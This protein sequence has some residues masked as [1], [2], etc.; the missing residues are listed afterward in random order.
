MQTQEIKGNL[1]KL[2]ATENLVVE[3]RNC[4]TAS[5]DVDN[6]VLT[7]PKWDRAS[8]TVYDLLVGHEVGHALYTPVW[9]TFNCPRDYVNVTEDAR[10]EKLMKRRY[11]GLRK[12]FF[13]GYNELH[14]Q[15]FF[16]IGDDDLDTFKLID[17]INLYFKIGSAGLDVT[18]TPEEQELVD[19]TA[20]AET[21]EQ[22]VA[23]A[24]KI[25]QF[26]KAEQSQMEKLADVPQS[27]GDGGSGSS[28][29]QES[30]QYN[31]SNDSNTTTNSDEGSESGDDDQ[32]EDVDGE[33]ASGG[34]TGDINSSDTQDAFDRA[35]EQLNNRFN[36]GRTI[37][38][39]MP[40]LNPSDYV[41]DWQT[42]H[43]WIDESRGEDADTSFADS[44]FRQF[45]KS[46]AKEV[47]YLVKEFECKKAAD[48]YSRSMTSRTGVLDTSKLH[49]FKYNEDLFKKVTVIP[50]GKNHGLLFIL[51]W[52]GSMSGVMLPTIK[53]LLTL[54]FFCKKVG[55]PFEVHA[56]TNEWAAA[57]RAIEGKTYPDY[58]DDYY[59]DGTHVVKNEMYVSKPFFRMMNLLSSR[60]NTKNF[61]RQCL[62]V[63]R[64]VFIMHYYDKYSPTIGM[65][66][67][68]TPL[69]ES[70]V[71]MK[72]IIPQ[73]KKSNNLNK[74]NVC[75]LTDGESC[76]S[77][78]GCEIVGANDF[79]RV[80]PRRIDY[81]DIV[82]R[83]R[84]IGRMYPKSNGFIDQTNLFI[85]NLKE[86]HPSVNVVGFRLIESTGL[87]N[88]CARYCNAEYDDI[89]N[90][91]KQWK[92]EKSAVMPK[93]ISYDALYAIHARSTNTEDTGLDVEEG[94]SKTQ[95][96]TAFK[97]ML[98]KKHNN[99]KILNSFISLIS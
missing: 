1:A 93:P 45:K 82:I 95:L 34:T 25:W 22:A 29:T 5:F 65:G 39:D 10:V 86:T 13:Q 35:T 92:K 26:A 16:G 85:Q 66:L 56:F 15:D 99:K 20:A 94:A 32:Y 40:K 90:M 74:V 19:E 4:S 42:I 44:E 7:L 8:N 30:S 79:V 33:G 54:V 76:T 21:F 58:D 71:V 36:G 70:I 62:N 52:S 50:E 27:G 69:N 14:S 31:E 73:F 38:V 97:K 43:D 51:D 2:L 91:Q 46:I 67:S 3:H 48:A 83:D 63:W 64:E 57:E 47:N 59:S 41:V 24:E 18:F 77:T 68:G 72:E 96:K 84:R 17:R 98:S 28:E 78:Y 87:S 9:K 81:G 80:V 75:I 60:S 23:I 53:Q 55:I 89:A 61:E 6:R 11:P 37:Y 49:T 88:F 12:S